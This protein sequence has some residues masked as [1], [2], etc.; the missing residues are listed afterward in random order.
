MAPSRV[1]QDSLGPRDVPDSVYWGIQTLRARENFP[2]SGLHASPHLVR[3]YALLKLA[4]VRAN[5]ALGVV[6]A[7]RGKAVEQAARE[8]AEGRLA[9]EFVVDV[10]QAGA[11]PLST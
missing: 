5:V 10:F 3:A 1:E 2:V 6:D 9:A 11:G 8:V 4:C 7:E